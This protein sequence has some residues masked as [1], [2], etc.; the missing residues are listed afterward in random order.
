MD[1]RTD[2]AERFDRLLDRMAHGHAPVTGKRKNERLKEGVE[3]MEKDK[4]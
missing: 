4:D 2:P 1:N 3:P